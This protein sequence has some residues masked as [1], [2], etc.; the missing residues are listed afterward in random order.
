MPKSK[1]ENF[2]FTSHDCDYHNLSIYETDEQKQEEFVDING[3]IPNAGSYWTVQ[4]TS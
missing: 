4:T 1:R 2:V 3:K